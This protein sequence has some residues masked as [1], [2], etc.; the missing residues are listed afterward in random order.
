MSNDLVSAAEIRR[1]TV[2]GA[3]TM[4][5]GIAQVAAMA[6]WSV[7]VYDVEERFVTAGLERIRNNLNA[8]VERGKVTAERRDETLARLKGTTSLEAAARDCDLVIEAVPEDAALKRKVFAA[9][10]DAA[11]ARAVLATNTSSLSVGDT[12]R[13]TRRPE[14][15]V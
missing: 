5:D 3:G 2:L 4:D 9:L 7:A 8:G 12:A 1:V 13:A 10:D 11:P 15:V 6:G 14:R